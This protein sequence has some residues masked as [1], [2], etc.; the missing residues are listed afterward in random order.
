MFRTIKTLLACALFALSTACAGAAPEAPATAE[1]TA[2]PAA[3]VRADFEA[4]YAGLQ[5]SHYDLYA[6]LPRADYGALYRRMHS[7]IDGPLPPL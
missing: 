4:L 2:L 7:D 5:A 3:A 1:S 6:H